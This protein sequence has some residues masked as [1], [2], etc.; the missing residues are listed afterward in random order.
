MQMNNNNQMPKIEEKET[1]KKEKNIYKILFFSV[2]ILILAGASLYFLSNS[3]TNFVDEKNM[4]IANESIHSILTSEEIFAK[5]KKTIVTVVASGLGGT[6]QGSGV[7]VSKDKILTNCHVIDGADNV[8]VLFDN[9]E[10]KVDSIYGNKDFDYCI[11]TTSNLPASL[12]NISDLKNISVG[13]KVYSIGTPQGFELTI[14]DGLVSGLRKV[15]N[16]SIIQ[17]TAPISPGSSGGGLFNEYGQLIG[18]TTMMLRDAQ[19]INFAIPAD[20]NKTIKLSKIET[21]VDIAQFIEQNTILTQENIKLFL[22]VYLKINCFREIEDVSLFFS[23]DLNRY[24]NFPN[25]SHVTIFN[26]NVTYCQRWTS[27]RY[28]L[29]SFQ[30]SGARVNNNLK[31]IDVVANISYNVSNDMKSINGMSDFSITLADEFGKI[32]IKSINDIKNTKHANTNKNHIN[33][34]QDRLARYAHEMITG[35]SIFDLNAIKITINSNNKKIYCVS[36][37]CKTEQEVLE[38]INGN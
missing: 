27:M 23:N 29:N 1:I 18:I 19:N 38:Y 10:Y 35:E 31:E 17:T 25:P 22:E 2:L 14:A 8:K 4:T 9:I 36:D 34:N 37:V 5:A 7:V 13:Q 20:L 21:K 28:Q 11:L 30:I 24:Y 3:K 33:P 32:K 6:S 26:E 12:A 16:I 15:E